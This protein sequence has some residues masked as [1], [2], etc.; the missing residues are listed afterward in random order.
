MSKLATLPATPAALH[1]ARFQA[2]HRAAGVRGMEF[3]LLAYFAGFEFTC[4]RDLHAAEHGETRGRKK[5]GA[6]N[7]SHARTIPFVEFLRQHVQCSTATAYRYRDHY[8]A[9][10]TAHPEVA[11]KLNEYYEKAVAAAALENGKGD[12]AAGAALALA[13]PEACKLPAKALHAILEQADAWGLE[14]LFLPDAD[15]SDESDASDDDE[16]GGRKLS[17]LV[18]FWAQGVF[19][20][21]KG[22]EYLRLPRPQLRTAKQLFEEA[23][24]KINAELEVKAAKPGKAA[25]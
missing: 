7:D 8:D 6:E 20:R 18:K 5:G 2:M 23:A 10:A 11:K 1:A 15:A 25:R 16:T 24:K 9:I 3:K 17:P 19:K 21:I 22:D 4:L 12:E 14:Q 13:S